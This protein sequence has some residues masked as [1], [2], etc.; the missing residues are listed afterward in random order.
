MALGI[1]EIKGW[2]S[3]SYSEVVLSVFIIAKLKTRAEII[4]ESWVKAMELRLVQNELAICH[5]A[6]GV[7]H[8]ENC[9]KHS[10]MY[11]SMLKENRVRFFS[12]SLLYLS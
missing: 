10:Q 3:C 8:Y 4:R 1:D 12:I 6:E 2:L 5:Q 11:L 9:R 7:N